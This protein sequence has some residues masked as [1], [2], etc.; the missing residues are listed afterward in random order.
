MTWIITCNRNESEYYF[1][2]RTTWTQN[3]NNPNIIK[4]KTKAYADFI[5]NSMDFKNSKAKFEVKEI[6]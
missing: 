2:T 1:N 5:F 6:P 4:F 3:F